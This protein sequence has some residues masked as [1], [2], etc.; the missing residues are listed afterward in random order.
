MKSS[1]TL[2][3]TVY[4]IAA[5]LAAAGCM[6]L[7]IETTGKEMPDTLKQSAIAARNS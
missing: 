7:P 6:L 3:T 4:A 1:V 5:L 2:A